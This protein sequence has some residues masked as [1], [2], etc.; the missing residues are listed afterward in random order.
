M[1]VL[2]DKKTPQVL[3]N[4]NA[5]LDVEGYEKSCKEPVKLLDSKWNKDHPR[6]WHKD[7]D[8]EIGNK[9]ETDADEECNSVNDKS[10]SEDMDIEESKSESEESE[11]K[12][13]IDVSNNN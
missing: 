3:V 4:W 5:M 12:S 10:D 9:Y 11:S 1:K 7:L 13:E 6:A 2:K 8:I